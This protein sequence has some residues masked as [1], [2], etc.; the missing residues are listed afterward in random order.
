RIL[1]VICAPLVAGEKAI[2]V[3]Q[4]DSQDRTKKFTQDDLKLLMG[5]ANQASVAVEN[6]RLHEDLIQR[7]RTQRDLELGQ[8]V[9]RSFLPQQ[10]PEVAGSQFYAHYN[11]A[12]T[13]G[14]DYYDF[15][16]Y[17][18]GKYGVLLGDVAGKGVPAALLMAKVSAEARS[19]MLLNPD[20]AKAIAR[21]NDVLAQIM[22]AGGMDRFVTLVAT[23]L[24]PVNHLVTIIN[25]GHMT[26]LIY[27]RGKMTLEDA[28]PTTCTALPLGLTESHKFEACHIELHAGDSLILYTDG[29]SDAL[30]AQNSAFSIE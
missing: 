30:S 29:V 7:E 23:V 11:A 13:I 15:I 27:R 2:G 4:L 17:P 26:P 22:Q 21:L 3:I 20:P 24:D 9:Q 18:D 19:C 6:A 28:M 14:G 1:S 16:P 25:A 5:V 8:Q 12:L 10:P